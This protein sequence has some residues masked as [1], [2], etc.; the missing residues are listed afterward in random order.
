MKFKKKMQK[1]RNVGK[2]IRVFSNKKKKLECE[3]NVSFVYSLFPYE[4]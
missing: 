4:E 1:Q 3:L 2:K